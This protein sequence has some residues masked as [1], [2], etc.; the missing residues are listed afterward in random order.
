MDCSSDQILYCRA[1]WLTANPQ[2]GGKPVGYV[3]E[4]GQRKPSSLPAVKRQAAS[5]SQVK[6]EPDEKD[7]K[8][9]ELLKRL[10]PTSDRTTPAEDRADQ[11]LS[12]DQTLG[13]AMEVDIPDV[14]VK[15]ETAAVSETA[16]G[17]EESLKH[18]DR[19][20]EDIK[21]NDL[22]PAGLKP[23]ALKHDDVKQESKLAR[24]PRAPQ[25]VS[26]EEVVDEDS[27][28]PGETSPYFTSAA[29]TYVTMPFIPR[30]ARR[31]SRH[32]MEQFIAEEASCG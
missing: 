9:A 4:S 26:L 10:A 17:K 18:G 2:T 11:P 31:A 13:V 14:A 29:D 23:N 7:V 3:P 27:G 22:E 1:V 21:P 30:P 5:A 20:L 8:F 15:R 19:N 16:E 6:T 28:R 25:K 32:L 24:F 12:N